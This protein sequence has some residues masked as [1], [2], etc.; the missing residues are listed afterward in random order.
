MG[1]EQIGGLTGGA[2]ATPQT[3]LATRVAG[4]APSPEVIQASAVRAPEETP[5]LEQIHDAVKKIEKALTPTAEDLQFSI[6]DD[7]GKVIIK[8][9]DTKTQTVLR[10]IPSKELLDIAKALDKMQGLLVKQKA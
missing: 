1:T 5:S 4:L 6:D 7:S 9:V 3:T 8:L 2:A 10:Q